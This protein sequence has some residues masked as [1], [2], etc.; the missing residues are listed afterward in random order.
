ML[1]HQENYFFVSFQN[2]SQIFLRARNAIN[3]FLDSNMTFDE[4]SPLKDVTDAH[5]VISE[6]TW[7]ICP[8]GKTKVA[9]KSIA[10]DVPSLC[11][12]GR[13][14]FHGVPIRFATLVGPG[15]LTVPTKLVRAVAA[16]LG[17]TEVRVTPS[18]TQ[19]AL[20]EAGE[21]DRGTVF[22]QAVRHESDVASNMLLSGL[23]E[24]WIDSVVYYDADIL[25]LTRKPDR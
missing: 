21:W 9:D 8:S 20:K 5:V 14:Y 25:V 16:R 2:G 15:V 19:V 17:A 22:G 7:L 18:T 4:R 1:T 13:G 11:S 23:L 6:R 10:I 12:D 3:L 24:E